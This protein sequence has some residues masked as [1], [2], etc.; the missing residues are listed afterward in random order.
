MRTWKTADSILTALRRECPVA[1]PRIALQVVREPLRLIGQQAPGL[2]EDLESAIGAHR[3]VLVG[4]EEQR[5]PPVAPPDR[6]VA[7]G[8]IDAEDPVPVR[9]AGDRPLGGDVDVEGGR[10]LGEAVEAGVE[11]PGLGGEPAGAVDVGRRQ[12]LLGDLLRP[13]SLLLV[14][15]HLSSQWGEVSPINIAASSLPLC[16]P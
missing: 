1:S 16:D 14:A 13:E 3:L 9:L 15:F 10:Q 5:E 11:A 12:L 4:M 6:V 8:G 2:G 7:G